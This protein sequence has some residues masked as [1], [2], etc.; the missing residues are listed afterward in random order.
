MKYTG[1]IQLLALMLLCILLFSSCGSAFEHV[2]DRDGTGELSVQTQESGESTPETEPQSAETD[3]DTAPTQTRGEEED[4]K[5]AE[6]ESQSEEESE[7]ESVSLGE[8]NG[9]IAALL[10]EGDLPSFHTNKLS[11]MEAYY[12]RYYVGALPHSRIIAFALLE[13]YGTYFKDVIDETDENLVTDALLA[14]YQ[15]AAGD[16]YAV[17]MDKEDLAANKQDFGAEYTGIGIY[18]GYH[19]MENTVQVLNVYENTPASEAGLLPGDYIL[20]VDGATVEEIG[21][22]E[23]VN[24]MRG[25]AGTSVTLTV[26]REGRELSF[27]MVRKHLTGISVTYRR[28]AQDAS[29]GYVK[30]EQFDEHTAEQ[31][32]AAID[33]LQSGGVSALVFDLRNN[34][35][36]QISAIVKVLDYLIADGLPIAHLRYKPGAGNEDEHYFAEDG[37]SVSLPITVLCNEYTI[38]AAELFAAALQDH[39]MATV[40]GDVTYGKG[41]AQAHV[42]FGDGT[43]F[44][45]SVACYDPPIGQNYEGKG[46]IPD[47]EIALSEEAAKVNSFLREDGI[48][49]QLQTA[50]AELNRLRAAK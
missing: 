8:D 39:G 34:G 21:Y 38:S 11:L 36:G 30:I 15:Q 45:I 32:K 28:L 10:E 40:V 17:Y 7:S 1:K 35:G 13:L 20:A 43:G 6:D 48:D 37:H 49:N 31:F 42:E 14:C 46:V 27:T 9:I 26:S 19:A 47:I 3:T 24:R 18:V 25:V 2:Y 50:V 23:L 4:S 12:K 41:M 44:S 5:E 33:A 16:K 22:Y 29:I